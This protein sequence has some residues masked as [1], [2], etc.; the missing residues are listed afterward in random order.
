MRR[1]VFHPEAERELS[2]ELIYYSKGRPGSDTR[3]L[4]AVEAATARAARHPLVG[5]P[6]CADNRSI[7]VRGFPFSV[8]YR[9]D[10]QVLTVIAISPHR[11]Q[12][13]YWVAR[14]GQQERGG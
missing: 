3:F 4:A 14:E 13:L 12:P 2:R 5:V 8:I 1:V 10:A 6:T 7:R 11:K 9:H